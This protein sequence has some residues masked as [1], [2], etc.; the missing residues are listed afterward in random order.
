MTK[1][2]ITLLFLVSILPQISFGQV[3]SIIRVEIDW[4]ADGTHSHK[5]TDQEMQAVVQM[6]A[7]HGITLIYEIGDSLQHFNV[8]RR[9]PADSNNIFEYNNGQD[10]YRGIRNAHFNHGGGGWHY[11]IFAHQYQDKQY[12][13][14]GS[15]GLGELPGDDFMVTLAGFGPGTGTSWDRAATFAHELGHNLGLDHA[16]NMDQNVVGTN[17]PVVPSIMTYFFQLTGVRT[18]LIC[19]GLTSATAN[20]FKELDYSNGIGCTVNEVS[21]DED[22]GIGMRKVDWNCDNFIGGT[23]A[24]DISNGSSSSGWCGATGAL[25]VLNDYNEWANIH[26]V[27]S[28]TYAAHGYA[29]REVDCITLEEYMRHRN[30]SS[31]GC[32]QPALVSETCLTAKM[33]YLRPGIGSGNGTCSYPFLGLSAAYSVVTDGDVLYCAAGHYPILSPIVLSRPCIL[34]GPGGAVLGTP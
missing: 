2:V 34:A 25:Q 15:S 19:Q 24:Q 32:P 13:A 7:C 21:L 26:D 11:C 16:G 1:T 17:V 10:T 23:V 3:P 9:D 30:S 31:G 28:A 14:S 20:L 33:W 22:F 5:P 18:N 8:I 6:F 29:S 4:M 27:T 12:N